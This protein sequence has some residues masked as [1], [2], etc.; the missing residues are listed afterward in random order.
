[1]DENMSVDNNVP[2]ASTSTRQSATVVASTGKEATDTR[3]TTEQ[4]LVNELFSVDES[5][6][7]P[8][9]KK[10]KGNSE[11]VIDVDLL[12]PSDFFSS[13]PLR[14]SPPRKKSRRSTVQQRQTPVIDL[15]GDDHVPSFG[16]GSS[17]RQTSSNN[18]RNRN[19]NNNDS[20]AAFRNL[21]PNRKEPL[22]EE[23]YV[24]RHDIPE[25]ERKW[26]QW[27][28]PKGSSFVSKMT[29]ERRNR[30]TFFATPLQPC[31]F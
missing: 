26:W 22:P 14:P 3:Q 18:H 19:D 21:D 12:I 2:V 5:P 8:P 9:P 7:P 4:D 24:T 23:L 15:N 27:S 31:I 6:P 28:P 10:N 29:P 16:S 30:C 17:R 20:Y 11:E 1:M 13:E 25:D